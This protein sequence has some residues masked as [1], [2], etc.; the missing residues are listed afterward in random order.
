MLIMVRNNTS[1]RLNSGKAKERAGMETINTQQTAP[2]LL[3]VYAFIIS[4]NGRANLTR[5]GVQGL[6]YLYPNIPISGDVY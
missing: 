1:R 3:M 2:I 5:P 4:L 6:S